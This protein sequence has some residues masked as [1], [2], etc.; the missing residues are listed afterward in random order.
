MARFAQILA[1]SGDATTKITGQAAGTA[2]AATFIGARRIIVINA[3]CAT[4]PVGIHIAFG[5]STMAA[6]TSA[7]YLIPCAQQTTF[8]MG[9]NTHV[10]IFADAGNGAV[11]DIYIQDLEG[12]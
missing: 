11:T 8:D 12:R 2:S 5:N 7:N 1:F 9:P 4:T 10:R 3:V 6:P